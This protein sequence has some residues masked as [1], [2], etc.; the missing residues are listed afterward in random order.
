[1]PEQSRGEQRES[2]KV[3]DVVRLRSGGP[4]MTVTHV[5]KVSGTLTTAWFTDSGDAREGEFP[6]YAVNVV[7]Q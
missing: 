7:A 1:M 3:G 2:I 5:V 6:T 4:E